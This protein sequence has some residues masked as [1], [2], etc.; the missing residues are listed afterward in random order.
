M[1]ERYVGSVLVLTSGKASPTSTIHLSAGNHSFVFAFQGI[2]SFSLHPCT[3]S[4]ISNLFPSIFSPSYICIVKQNTNGFS[5][6]PL[7]WTTPGASK[8]STVGVS[9]LMYPYIKPY[10]IHYIFSFLFR[11]FDLFLFIIFCSR[12]V[13]MK[14]TFCGSDIRS[15][16]WDGVTSQANLEVHFF[17]VFFNFICLFI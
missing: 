15:G 17:F 16:T 14:H 5:V 12:F 3:R 2:Y 8:F 10:P 4:Y 6:F 1:L 11:F 9:Q 7:K 13:L